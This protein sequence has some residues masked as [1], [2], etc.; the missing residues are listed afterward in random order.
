MKKLITICATVMLMSGLASAADID[1]WNAYVIRQGGGISPA[2]NDVMFGGTTPAKEFV[3][4]A[5]NMKAAWGTNNLN[6]LTIGDITELA[7]TR[8]DDPTRF[9]AGSGPAVAPYF[10][11]WVTDGL[12]NFA[13]VAN[14][15]SNG[16][17]YPGT[18][19]WNITDLAGKTAKAYEN[20]NVSWITNLATTNNVAGLQFDDL[21]GLTIQ[22]P[23]IAQLTASWTGLG[24]GAPRELGTNV[25]YG[26]NWVFGDTLSNYVSG[27]QGY[28]VTNPIATPEP[29]TMCMLGLG[30]LSL[31]RRKH[32]A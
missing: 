24:G 28:V 11:I 5:G 18:S 4:S 8:L 21:Y 32:K 31:I 12:G 15:P 30:A 7:I 17:E 22:A 20:S 26:F 13:V 14:E 19:E 6:G 23:T 9:I 29:A 10:N 27:A 3:I 25:A 2:I 1:G 16:G